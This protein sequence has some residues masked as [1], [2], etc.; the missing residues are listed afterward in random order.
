[1]EELEVE[2]EDEPPDVIVV[3]ADVSKLEGSGGTT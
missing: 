3:V 1:M 2:V